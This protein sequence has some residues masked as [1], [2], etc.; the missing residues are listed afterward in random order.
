MGS[1]DLLCRLVSYSPGL[2]DGDE[3][4]ISG[5]D[6]VDRLAFLLEKLNKNQLKALKELA[7]ECRKEMEDA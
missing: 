3:D 4:G 7:A 5:A 2:V 6:V 1:F